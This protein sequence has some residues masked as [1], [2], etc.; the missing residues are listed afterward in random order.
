MDDLLQLQ[1]PL[2][3]GGIRSVN[4]F[5]GRLLAGKDL[6]REQ[7][8]RRE[9]DWRL[10][11]ALGSGVAFGLEVDEDN[12]Q[13]TPS[14]PVLRVKAGLA[15]NRLGQA[16]RLVAQVSVALVRRFDAVAANCLFTNCTPLSGGSYIAGAG[17]YLLTVAPA[18]SSEGRAATNGMD[19]ANVRC[20]T[21]ATVEALQFRLL[22]V[23]PTHYTDLD[24]AS[25]QFR[26]RLAYRCFGIEQWEKSLADPRKN[27]LANYG[28]LDLLRSEGLDDRDVPLA[29][30]YWTAG[31]LQFIDMWSVRRRLAPRSLTTSSLS[32]FS[33]RRLAEAEA[34]F[35]Q[36]Q[37]QADALLRSSLSEAAI[38]AL[39]A[40]DYFRYLPAAAAIPTGGSGARTFT[41]DQFLDGLTHRTPVFIEGARLHA[42]LNRSLAYPPIDLGSHELIWLYL[43]RQNIQAI[44]TVSGTKPQQFVL[45]ASGHM[46]FEGAAHFDVNRWDYANYSGM[47]FG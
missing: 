37:D 20:N 6:S 15:I 29:L 7:E 39:H 31:G 30:I 32:P 44:D 33:P 11:L 34:I 47:T 46:P 27:D 36:F 8:A 38:A 26:N 2:K 45:F 1:E 12:A 40:S 9:S 18:E 4:F 13:S 14:A 10:G 43:V 41:V 24:P 16:L 35:L 22:A 17:I 5:N 3:D 21:D 23:N 19:P 28:L 25:K 42:I